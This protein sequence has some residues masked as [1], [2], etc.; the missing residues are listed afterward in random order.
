VEAE[1]AVTFRVAA[2]AYDRHVGRYG[3]ELAERLCAVAAVG[4]GQSVLDVGCGPGALTA[5]L[6]GLVGPGRV[7]AVDP[8]ETFVEACRTRVP[9]ADVRVAAAEALPFADASFDAVLSQLVINF[10]TDAEAGVREMRRV[11]R[12][13][14]TVAAAVW[15]YAGGM[16]LLRSF[17]D[18]VGAVDPEGAPSRDEGHTMRYCD[19]SELSG[20]WES[21]GLAGV[22]TGALSVSAGYDSFDDLWEP[23]EAGV[24]PS[25]A[26][27]ASLGDAARRALRDEWRRRLGSPAGGFELT[28]RAWY[29]VGRT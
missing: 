1:G 15:D 25:G 29:A 23:F 4:P 27:A 5:V 21:T 18:S 13:G 28:A 9:G 22:R 2:A 12:P 26:Y 19:E 24:G 14:G 16:T 17:W 11:T 10:M 7:S 20:L 6:S 3:K 8:S